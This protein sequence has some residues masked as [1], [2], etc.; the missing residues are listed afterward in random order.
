MNFNRS[1]L[2]GVIFF[3]IFIFKPV[4][5]FAAA[6][7][8][9]GP[10]NGN[11]SDA[12]NWSETS[13]GA[14]GA[15]VPTNDDD[16]YFDPGGNTS[17][18]IDVNLFAKSITIGP[19]FTKTVTQKSNEVTVAG[20]F[21][22]NSGAFIGSFDSSLIGYWKLDEESVS[23]LAIDFSGN[24]LNKSY[25]NIFL[26]QGPT[27]DVNSTIN[28]EN[29]KSVIFDG[30]DDNIDVST[31]QLIDNASPKSIFTWIKIDPNANVFG[32]IFNHN[33]GA[34][35]TLS[36][37]D[38]SGGKFAIGGT[39]NAN[40]NGNYGGTAK[41]LD[42]EVWYHVGYT[43]DGTDWIIYIDGGITPWTTTAGVFGFNDSEPDHVYIARRSPY[44]FKG[45]LDD[46]RL[47]NRALSPVE[48]Q[49]LAAGDEIDQPDSTITVDNLIIN[50]GSYRAGKTTNI[51]GDFSSNSG[52]FY[53]NNGEIIYLNINNLTASTFGRH[54]KNI[55]FDTTGSINLDGGFSFY[56][57]TDSTIIE[58]II[59][60]QLGTL[61]G[62]YIKD[63][64]LNYVVNE[65]TSTCAEK[66]SDVEE[67]DG[68]FGDEADFGFGLDGGG[69]ILF[70]EE[71][72]LEILE[73]NVLCIYPEY[74]I[75]FTD[76]SEYDSVGKTIKFGIEAATDIVLADEMEVT[77]SS[78]PLSV[79]G[80]TVLAQVGFSTITFV[81]KENNTKVFY[82]DN[83][84]GVLYMLE[85]G[86]DPQRL[87]SRDVFVEHANFRDLTPV[88]SNIGQ[89]EVTLRLR[90]KGPNYVGAPVVQTFKTT[91][92]S[93]Y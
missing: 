75:D 73:G 85:E 93:S 91:I 66:Y 8:W 6:R 58:S 29:P 83:E 78:T 34:Q 3:S 36:I 22:V 37:A 59:F 14:G 88:G 60:N 18:I 11:T 48:V 92:N 70:R 39:P 82:V 50:G 40:I 80:S 12:A 2:F 71:P 90:Y 23:E 55:D 56:R 31:V 9:V 54:I 25:N 65:G 51:Y 89:I 74:K 42:P 81:D 79:F 68:Q 41:I 30:S 17:A 1:V 53:A 5:V 15:A 43:F 26:P 61:S 38:S 19:D 45:S 24:G 35:W 63:V 7:Y 33:V 87:T 64:K 44:S 62:A 57:E 16:I 49:T 77:L 13:G 28:F 67:F 76:M 32:R 20:D 27:S 47:Y 21:T 86:E 10:E 69:D 4:D 52:N 84:E 46:I 72:G